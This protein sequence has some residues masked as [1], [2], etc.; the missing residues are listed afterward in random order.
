MP[1]TIFF[2]AAVLGI[3]GQQPAQS[4]EVFLEKG[5]Q[6]IAYQITGEKGKVDFRYLDAGSYK[7][8]VVFPQQSGKFV[9]T[10]PKFQTL[11]KACYHSKN[12]TYYYQSNEG[13]FALKFSGISKI[14]SE[15]FQLVL[16]EEEHAEKKFIVILEF[17]A[18]G[19]NASLGIS[20]R[21]ITAARFQKMAEK[22]DTNISML[23][24]PNIR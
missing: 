18:H 16:R 20:I 6:L 22:A 15:N 21:A 1:L 10:K 23:S 24:I 17:G 19:K 11:A 14:R 5:S 9:E 8:S 7:L 4:T 13:Y 2:L 12:K 3:F